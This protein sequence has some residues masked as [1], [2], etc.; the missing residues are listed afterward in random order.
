MAQ[1]TEDLQTP[2]PTSH[3]FQNAGIQVSSSNM[4]VIDNSIR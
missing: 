1:P 4:M 2:F 3:K